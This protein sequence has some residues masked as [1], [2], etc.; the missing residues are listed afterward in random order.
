MSDDACTES[1]CELGKAGPFRSRGQEASIAIVRTADALHRRWAAVI[2]PHGIT[3]QQYNVLR[4][5]RGARGKPLPTLEIGNR[6]IEQTPGITRLLDR[7]EEKGL[8][9]RE[10]CR[11]DR[12]LVHCWIT[13]AGLELLAALDAPV[14]EVDEV[15]D[16]SAR[17]LSDDELATLIGFLER[18][19]A[20][21]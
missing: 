7:L 2:E 4:I 15:D 11:E 9:R 14:D 10:R 19:R 17:A 6:L 3:V 21:R 20:A 16:V 8:A 1:L 5:L 13:D 18:I 12:R